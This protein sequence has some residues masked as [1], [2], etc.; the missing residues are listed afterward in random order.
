MT[1]RYPISLALYLSSIVTLPLATS[2]ANALSTSYPVA[3]PAPESSS[4]S[5]ANSA[6]VDRER[7]LMEK[8]YV[9]RQQSKDADA[10]AVYREAYALRHDAR[11]LAQIALALEAL[12]NWSQ[13]YTVLQEALAERSHPW[14]ESNRTILDSELVRIGQRLGRVALVVQPEGAT[15]RLN[16]SLVGTAPLAQP[17]LLNPGWSTVEVELAGYVPYRHELEIQPGKEYSEVVRLTRPSLPPGPSE[18]RPMGVVGPTHANRTVKPSRYNPL[19]LGTALG[20]VLVAAAAVIPWSSANDRVDQL[21]QECK[22]NQK[23]P[24]AG[25]SDDVRRLDR[26]TNTL[27]ISGFGITVTST[28]LYLTVPKAAPQGGTGVAAWASPNGV[29]ISYSGLY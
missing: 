11:P 7:Q 3:T 14:I 20:G 26:I 8:G 16:G 24:F 27:L 22:G 15:V 17:L 6:L 25:T 1:G 18:G 9:L 5:D 23:C 29:V 2:R 13:A 28:V 10:L 12:G 21:A 19:W 4:G